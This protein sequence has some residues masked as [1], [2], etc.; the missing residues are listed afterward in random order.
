[1]TTIAYP[2]YD[3]GFTRSLSRRQSMS[4][5]PPPPGRPY[6]DHQGTY[7][8]PVEY[9]QPG[10]YPSY[11][12]SVPPVMHRVPS[13]PYD[14]YHDGYYRET[15]V[16]TPG[17]VTAPTMYPSTSMGTRQR[18]QSNVGYAPPPVVTTYR[19]GSGTHIKFKRKGAFS[20]GI[21]LAEAQSHIRLSGND[22]Y[23]IYD[24]HPDTRGRI[25]LR[26]RVSLCLNITMTI[27]IQ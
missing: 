4:Y 20:A 6:S 9:R 16:P 23:T 24:L 12:H 18:R 13:S 26:V 27:Q 21:S 15:V 19:V 7:D 10:V 5:I 1:M 14:E 22:H 25:L 3:G 17:P 8:P 11:A 2:P